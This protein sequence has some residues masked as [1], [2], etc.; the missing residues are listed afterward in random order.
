M[1]TYTLENLR[2]ICQTCKV[3]MRGE[4]T[5]PYVSHGICPQCELDLLAEDYAAQFG[6]SA[7]VL[8]SV[9]VR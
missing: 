9:E 2:T 4:P 5:A 1:T 6:V 8:A 3:H 7:D